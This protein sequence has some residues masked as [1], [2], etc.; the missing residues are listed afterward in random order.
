MPHYCAREIKG[1]AA[2]CPGWFVQ[3]RHSLQFHMAKL[4]DE[5]INY[6]IPLRTVHPR[7]GL[8]ANCVHILTSEGAVVIQTERQHC[9]TTPAC[10]AGTAHNPPRRD[11]A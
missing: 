7:R 9:S 10:A 6:I 1:E 3:V 8:E 11:R 2:S 4:L 5:R